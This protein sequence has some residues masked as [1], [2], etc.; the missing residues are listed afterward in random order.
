VKDLVESIGS[1]SETDLKVLGTLPAERPASPEEVASQLYILPED[2]S[3]SLGHL[4]SLAFVQGTDLRVR[5]LGE[6]PLVVLT[7]VGKKAQKL[8]TILQETNEPD[9]RMSGLA[10]GR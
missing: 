3:V 10:R 1:L 5:Y 7:D 9:L 2:V 6:E 4:K 8:S